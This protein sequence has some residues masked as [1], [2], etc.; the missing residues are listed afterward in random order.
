MGSRTWTSVKANYSS[1]A[2]PDNTAMVAWAQDVHNTLLSIGL[3]LE[4]TSWAVQWDFSQQGVPASNVYT[5]F[6]IYEL[7]DSLSGTLPIFIKIWFGGHKQQIGAYANYAHQPQCSIQIGTT[8]TAGGVLGGIL[9]EPFSVFSITGVGAGSGGTFNTTP[10]QNYFH[11]SDIGLFLFLG[12]SPGFN[13][14]GSYAN[15]AMMFY[16]ERLPD[17]NGQ[18]TASGYT[19]VR[20]TE[21]TVFDHGTA[22][23]PTSRAPIAR[24]YSDA[25]DLGAW[26]NIPAS[27]IGGAITATIEGGIVFHPFYHICPELRAMRGIFGYYADTLAALSNAPLTVAGG[28]EIQVKALGGT[29]AS[30]KSSYGMLVD[31]YSAYFYLAAVTD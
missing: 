29:A 6:K 24:S 16:L 15:P 17:A 19:I 25:F 30:A 23:G 31:T 20:P 22:Q 10:T 7:N 8:V 27:P 18:P 11:K 1:F 26:Y 2:T 9:S 12:G 28:A 14:G 13:A 3:V 5:L 21:I 4:P